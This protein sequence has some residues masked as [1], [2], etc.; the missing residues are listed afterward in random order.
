MLGKYADIELRYIQL[1]LVVHR[2]AEGAARAALCA[3]DQG[4]FNQ[5]HAILLSHSLTWRNLSVAP[6]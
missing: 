5:M 2:Y 3:E 4:K 1:P 6:D